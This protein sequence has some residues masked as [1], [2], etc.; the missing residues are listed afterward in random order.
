MSVWKRGR[1]IYFNLPD[2]TVMIKQWI[3]DIM[4]KTMV[5]SVLAMTTVTGI[6]LQQFILMSLRV[7]AMG[8]YRGHPCGDH[9]PT[10]RSNHKGLRQ[11]LEHSGGHWGGRLLPCKNNKKPW[12]TGQT[13]SIQTHQCERNKNNMIRNVPLKGQNHR[14]PSEGGLGHLPVV[15]TKAAWM[16]HTL[17]KSREVL[18]SNRCI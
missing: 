12:V 11:R 15:N 7:I 3:M 10:S 8:V 9:T 18:N 4:V 16:F 1:I 5:K 13:S 2:G 14:R 17:C 6:S